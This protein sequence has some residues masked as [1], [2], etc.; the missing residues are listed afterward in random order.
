M[1][2]LH[3]DRREKITQKG[4]EQPKEKDHKLGSEGDYTLILQPTNKPQIIGT[5]G[6]TH[7]LINGCILK[8]RIKLI[9]STN[10]PT[11]TNI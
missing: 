3:G 11:T 9:L 4:Q 1:G 2:I 5:G 8:R 6:K 10:I 7:T